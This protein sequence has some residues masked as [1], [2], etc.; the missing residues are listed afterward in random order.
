[1]LPYVKIEFANGAL[2]ATE[3][4][5]DGVAGL[6][7]TGVAVASKFA[8]N[9]PYLISR[10]GDLQELGITANAS[11]ANATIYKAVKE[12]YDEAPEGTKLW[13][14]AS[15][16]TDGQDDLVDKT[17]AGNAKKLIEAANDSIRILFVA[18]KDPSDYSP[19]PSPTHRHSPN[20]RRRPCSPHCSSSLKGDITPAL[21]RRWRPTRSTTA[22]TTACAWS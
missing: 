4:M 8:L 12:F 17:K 22:T 5:E 18:V 16:D 3:P 13:L 1:M 20:G 10:L 14:L 11:D 15:A 9:T 19:V 21:P 7:A 6:V 2:G